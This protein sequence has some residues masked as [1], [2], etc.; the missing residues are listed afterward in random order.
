[1]EHFEDPLVDLYH[2]YVRR[3][4]QRDAAEEER[5]VAE[6][7]Q[8]LLRKW[9]KQEALVVLTRKE[10]REGIRELLRRLYGLAMVQEMLVALVASL[11]VVMAQGISVLQRRRELGLLRAVGAT[12]AQVLRSVLAE[13]VLMGLIGTLVGVAVG[14][15]VEHYVIKVI[16]LEEAGFTMPVLFPWS[17]AGLIVV[18]TLATATLAGLGPALRAMRQSIPEAIAYE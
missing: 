1:L 5:N 10:L 16:L 3:S 18:V 4:D 9:G 6:V 17:W 14:V 15:P 11:G 12:R 7:R 8:A 2:V 13:A